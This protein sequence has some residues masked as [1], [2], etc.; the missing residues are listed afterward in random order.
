MVCVPPALRDG[1]RRQEVHEH[2]WVL[3]VAVHEGK[4][5]NGACMVTY[6]CTCAN[7]WAGE[8]CEFDLD[9]CASNPCKNAATCVDGVGSC[10]C[11]CPAGH[12]GYNCEQGM[13]E[14]SSSP[15]MSGG[16]CS[17]S[18]TTTLL[19]DRYVCTYAPGYAGIICD[20]H[21]DERGSS[22][23]LPRWHL[24]RT[25][26]C[27]C[28]YEYKDTPIG[29]RFEQRSTS[30]C[31]VHSTTWVRALVTPLRHTCYLELDECCI[32]PVPVRDHELRPRFLVQLRVRGRLQRLQLRDQRTTTVA[33]RR[34]RT[35]PRARI[36]S[37]STSAR[38]R[39][40][41]P[42]CSATRRLT[43]VPLQGLRCQRLGAPPTKSNDVQYSARASM[44]GP[45]ST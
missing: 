5:T 28:G 4:C 43:R 26:A 3:V 2:C 7:S 6:T 38:A 45:A 23:C 8:H 11:V 14:G 41:G 34:A 17:H 40:R 25:R 19:V 37:P 15:C 31:P 35:A 29:T 16:T 32:R 24:T 30:V 18:G 42:A 13:Y 20:A 10:G 22:P 33:R 12:A 36:R 44:Y 9:E 39:A 1:Q 21:T 27:T